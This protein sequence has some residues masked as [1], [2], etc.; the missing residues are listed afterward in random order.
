MINTNLSRKVTLRLDDTQHRD[1][2]VVCAYTH[3]SIQNLIVSYVD[4]LLRYQDKKL[5]TAEK[6]IVDQLIERSH[7]IERESREAQ[8]G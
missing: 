5:T 1:L 2:K 7:T 4:L 3:L 6:I 8:H